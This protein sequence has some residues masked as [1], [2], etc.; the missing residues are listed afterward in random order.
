M[1]NDKSC[2]AKVKLHC[3][4]GSKCKQQQPE[5]ANKHAMIIT[6]MDARIDPLQWGHFHEGQV[7]VARNGGGR[8]SDDM[9]RS[10]VLAIR[11]FKVDQVF[12]VHHTDCGLEKVSD[13]EVR[14][15]LHKSLGPAHLGD[16]TP[17]EKNN[18]DR[19]RQAD[20]VSFLAFKNLEESVVDDV[21][22]FKNSPLVSEKVAVSGYVY[23]VETGAL[24]EVVTP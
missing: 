1:D 7:F 14:H 3:C 24:R 4:K 10:A 5:E 12:I 2:S 23:D 18:S 21:Y 13:P 17:T 22:R 20:Y 9:I 6:C 11:L 16:P 19:F 8:V 15:L